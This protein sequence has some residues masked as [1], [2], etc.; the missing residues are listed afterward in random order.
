[1][2][3][4]SPSQPNLTPQWLYEQIMRQIEPD[5]LPESLSGLQEKYVGET[6]EE[7]TVRMQRYEE[8]FAVFDRSLASLDAHLVTEAREYRVSRQQQ[9]RMH[10]ESESQ[11]ELRHIERRIKDAS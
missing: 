8:A 4:Q 6:E 5:L 9:S 10:E 7:H 3:Q 11:E 2:V 1:M